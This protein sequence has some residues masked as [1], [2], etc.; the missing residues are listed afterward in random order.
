MN[1]MIEAVV[2]PC[3][4]KCNGHCIMCT[5]YKRKSNDLPIS[6]FEPLFAHQEMSKLKSINITGG[7]PTLR[8]DLPQLVEMIV[9]YCTHIKEIIINTNGFCTEQI[10]LQI[11]DIYKILRSGTKLWVYVSLDALDN[12]AEEIRGVNAAHIKAM[13]TIHALKKSEKNFPNLRIGL[14]CTITNKN[15]DKLESVYQYAVENE[16]YSDFIYATV[17]TSYINSQP[18]K[19]DFI[20]DTMQKQEV[21][22]FFEKLI[23][24]DKIS[25]SKKYYE[26]LIMKLKGIEVVKSCIFREHRG[27]LLEADGK[28]RLCGMTE[29]SYLGDLQIHTIDEI[30][31]RNLEF[32]EEYCNQCQTDSYYSWTDE[33]QKAIQ[34]DMFQNIIRKR[35]SAQ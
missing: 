26:I 16:I 22:R 24:Y 31:H 17:N 19:D 30:L 15:F 5:I 12:A 1:K 4:Y 23:L 3:T 9:S 18:N 2:F 25:S 34:A 35:K 33:A 14:S 20:L 21:I 32:M 8:K 13:N 10:L 11:T 28:V 29:Q 27:L 7:E 6:F